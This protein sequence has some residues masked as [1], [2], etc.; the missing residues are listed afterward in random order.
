MKKISSFYHS[1][2]A[3]NS[4]SNIK[5]RKQTIPNA[6]KMGYIIILTRAKTI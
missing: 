6:Q 1:C 3:R 2:L 4:I 5:T